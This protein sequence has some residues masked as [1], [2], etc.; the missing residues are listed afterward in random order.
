MGGTCSP[1]QSETQNDFTK[2][3]NDYQTDN[4]RLKRQLEELKIRNQ[5]GTTE[6]QEKAKQN[7]EVMKELDTMKKILERKDRALVKGQLEA[8]L[9]SK[10]TIMRTFES[11]TR[12]CMEGTM[13]KHHRPRSGLTKS[14][15]LKHVEVL[16]T[17]GELLSNE[18]KAGF[19]TLRY[20]NSKGAKTAKQCQVLTV[21]LNDSKSHEV[22]LQLNVFAEGAIKQIAFTCETGENKDEW[23]KCITDALNEVR[24][25]WEWMN[26]EF[27]VELEFTKE[28]I[29]IRVES[30]FVDDIEYDGKESEVADKVEGT[31]RKAARE[32]G[33]E[34]N[35]AQYYP[36]YVVKELEEKK[37]EKP[38]ELMVQKILNEDLVKEGLFEDCIVRKINDTALVGMVWSDQIELLKCTPKP[39]I[40]TFTGKNFIKKKCAPTHSY[41]SILKELVADGENKVKKA[42]HDLVKG[43]PFENELQCSINQAATIE[44]LL[45]DQRRLMIL[46]QN[47]HVQE[48]EL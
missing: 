16:L 36:G 2:L 10:A 22:I 41:F 32:F 31:K 4:E 13:M 7:E 47:L 19:V 30:I 9:R 6:H 40:I 21:I 26:E 24:T 15:K 23:V 11:K 43:T 8:V 3:I 25:T 1:E 29:G 37:L 14:K 45:S 34:E 48:M 35:K 12:L 42:F 44:A 38:C 28:K 46:L 18:Y 20:A 5:E 17:E 39:F 27:T 33:I